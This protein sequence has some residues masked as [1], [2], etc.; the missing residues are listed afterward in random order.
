MAGQDPYSEWELYT[1]LALNR[2]EAEEALVDS[3]CSTSIPGVVHSSVTR[4][5]ALLSLPS[6]E[7]FESWE[8]IPSADSGKRKFPSATFSKHVG[9]KVPT[10]E[11][12]GRI[13]QAFDALEREGQT[14]GLYARV[15]EKEKVNEWVVRQCI[16]KRGKYEE[17]L[18]WVEKTW[19]QRGKRCKGGRGN[20]KAGRGVKIIQPGIS[21]AKYPMAESQLLTR[22]IEARQ[23]NGARVR[24]QWVK[25][26]MKRA[27]EEHYPSAVFS[28]S[29]GW[30][31]RWMKR[32]NIVYRRRNNK[33]SKSI[34]QLAPDVC[35]FINTI[36]TMRVSSLDN[37]SSRDSKWGQ[38]TPRLIYNVDQV[39]FLPSLS[40]IL[41]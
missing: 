28:G 31:R 1:P 6:D 10:L 30:F 14:K 26:E 33:K 12:R 5:P 25:T 40:L 11:K 32:H 7:A 22:F 29:T 35:R 19:E 37:D 39:F 41:S 9:R 18:K 13:I 17:A 34:A 20:K 2:N 27:V 8:V 21:K 4:T 15:S 36:R 16:N 23:T 3:V 38:W 24:F